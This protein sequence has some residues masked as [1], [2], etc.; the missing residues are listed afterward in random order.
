MKRIA[1]FASG[2]GSNAERIS[3]HFSDHAD[4][5]VTLILTNNPAAGV[6]ARA[7]QL[8]IPVVVFDKKTFVDSKRIVELLQRQQIDLIVLAGFLMLVPATL[9]R[10]FP[11]R[12]IN[13]HPALLPKYG[14]PGMYGE[15]VHEAVAAAGEVESGITIH[16]VDE[17]YDEGE[18][19]YQA[20]CTLENTDRAADIAE[21]VLRLEHAHFPS[22]VDDVLDGLE[23]VQ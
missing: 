3:Q 23:A 9:I 5:E 12:I 21:K 19:I 10:A 16:Y 1:I 6:I 13:I 2:S 18:I 20:S 17:R 11:R 7:R 15:H 8:H 22:V 14:G 4:V